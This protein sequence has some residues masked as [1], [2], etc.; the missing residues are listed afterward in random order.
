MRRHTD[1]EY[2][3]T[4]RPAGTQT[5]RQIY[6]QTK[7]REDIHINEQTDSETDTPPCIQTNAHTETHMDGHPDRQGDRKTERQSEG[8]IDAQ[9]SGANKCRQTDAHTDRPTTHRQIEIHMYTGRR[10]TVI[11]RHCADWHTG[12]R[13]DGQIHRQAN[14]R[15]QS[16][17]GE[18]WYCEGGDRA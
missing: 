18:C 9:T 2:I 10:Q 15:T 17:T 3:P 4:D 13:G 11:D 7:R 12:K 8:Q 6:R 16:R 14:T 1:T 5:G